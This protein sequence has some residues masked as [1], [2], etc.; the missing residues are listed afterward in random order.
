MQ[1]FS[2]ERGGWS[3]VGCHGWSLFG[4][5]E[6]IWITVNV[7][8]KASKPQDDTKGEDAAQKRSIKKRK[9]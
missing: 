3:A 7:V 5:L 4:I 6:L 1:C 8:V 9:H 2:E